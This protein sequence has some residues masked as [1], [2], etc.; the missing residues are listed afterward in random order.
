MR[1][2]LPLPLIVLLSGCIGN[3]EDLQQYVESVKKTH[4]AH[5][6]PLK[7]PPKFEH[8]QYDADLLRSPFVPPSRELTAEAIDTTKDCRQPD[9]KRRKERL[10]TYALDN[11]RMRGTLSNNGVI[12]AL[13]ETPDSNVY[14]IGVGNY[15]GLFNGHITKINQ[16]SI[17]ITEL[18]PDG[19]GCWTERSS[20]LDLTGGK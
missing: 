8:F 6:P 7:E 1:W 3:H 2:I 15:I 10:E 11:L 20:S 19:S 9:L 5:I 18:V 14:R 13:I 12:W 4:V 17:E 16:N